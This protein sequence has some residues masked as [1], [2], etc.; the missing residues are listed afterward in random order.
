MA[1]KL[2]TDPE[3]DLRILQV[4]SE[5]VP[6]TVRHK[7]L[8]DGKRTLKLIAVDAAACFYIHLALEVM[9]E[10][11]PGSVPHLVTVY[12]AEYKIFRFKIEVLKIAEYICRYR[13]DPFRRSRF[14]SGNKYKTFAQ[15][16]ML[17]PKVV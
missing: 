16:Y 10:C 7:I 8:R 17:S 1:K 12:I 13:Y 9:P 4:S 3:R 14:C 5:A 2:L 6:E 15:I 11:R